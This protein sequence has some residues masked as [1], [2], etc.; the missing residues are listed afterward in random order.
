MQQFFDKSMTFG[1]IDRDMAIR[2]QTGGFDVKKVEETRE[3]RVV[4][5][6]QEGGPGKQF[7]RIA[8]RSGG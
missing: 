3:T 6:V 4:V 7:L 2:N 8:K 1:R 5:L